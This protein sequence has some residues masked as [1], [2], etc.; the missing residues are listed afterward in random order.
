MS[1]PFDFTPEAF[2]NEGMENAINTCRGHGSYWKCFG[3]VGIDILFKE[4]DDSIIRVIERVD[5]A[6]A[7]LS[8]DSDYTITFNNSKIFTILP[9]SEILRS[10]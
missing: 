10:V 9:E 7:A 3:Y 1:K 5:K 8:D 6:D 2:L 4:M